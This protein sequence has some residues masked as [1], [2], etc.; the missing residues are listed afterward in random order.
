M[1]HQNVVLLQCEESSQASTSSV[2]LLFTPSQAAKYRR[3][4]I[5]DNTFNT[6]SH[7]LKLCNLIG[8]DETFSVRCAGV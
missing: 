6:N 4:L 5:Y 1:N 8:M 3:I 2:K 7:G